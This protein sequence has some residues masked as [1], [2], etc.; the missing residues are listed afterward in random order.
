MKDVGGNTRPSV[1]SVKLYLK[2]R[3]WVSIFL[4]VDTPETKLQTK[5]FYLKK[6]G[7]CTPLVDKT[8]VGM[9]RG[10]FL[11][12]HPRRGERRPDDG[13]SQ[14]VEGFITSLTQNWN[15]Y[16]RNASVYDQ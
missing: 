8:S 1:H 3:T 9:S 14:L 5:S 12:L 6:C 15:L 2:P 13:S 11:L 16:V 7:S 4:C 10:V